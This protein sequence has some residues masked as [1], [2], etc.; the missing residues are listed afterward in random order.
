M[1]Q[2]MQLTLNQTDTQCE[3]INDCIVI[4]RILN[5][6][7][8]HQSLQL[9]DDSKLV[10][11]LME[12]VSIQYQHLIDDFNHIIIDHHDDMESIYELIHNKHKL[13]LP[14]C[15]IISC[16][17]YKRSNRNRELDH[18]MKEP[19]I[20]N[21]Q[22]MFWQDLFDQIHCFMLH[23][24]DGGLRIK[25]NKIYNN[26][27]CRRFDDTDSS[28]SKYDSCFDRNF[29][30]IC[31]TASDQNKSLQK[32]GFRG[33]RTKTN[34]FN[35]NIGFI[36]SDKNI[37]D[38]RNEPETTFMDDLYMFLKQYNVNTAT[39]LRLNEYLIEHQYDTDSVLSD[40][41]VDDNFASN[42]AQFLQNTQY[43]NCVVEYQ[44]FVERKKYEEKQREEKLSETSQQ[45]WCIAQQ[46]M[47]PYYDELRE[48]AARTSNA[49]SIGFTFFY[50]DYYR[51]GDVTQRWMGNQNDLL[52]Y[53]SS[54]LFIRKKYKSLKDEVLDNEI[55][56]ISVDIYNKVLTKAYQYIHCKTVKYIVASDE[57]NELH[58]GITEGT[59]ISIEHLLSI[60]F[61]TNLSKLSTAFSS[62]FR[63]LQKN[64]SLESIKTRNREYWHWSKLIR[65][66]VQ[67][68]GNK[69][70]HERGQ[71]FYTGISYMIL[72]AFVIRLCCP[73]STTKQEEV[74]YN[75]ANET[76]IVIRINNGSNY[77]SQ[78]LR[79]FDCSWLSC[80]HD[81]D[82]RLFC[83]GDNPLRV[84]SVTLV[85]S[86]YNLYWFL[87]PLFYLDCMVSGVMLSPNSDAA[88]CIRKRDY[89]IL[90]SLINHK[91][92]NEKNEI[93]PY[94][95]DTFAA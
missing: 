47:K 76:G 46:T 94:I 79:Y 17:F 65:E 90:M 24:F 32:L 7:Q 59:L 55:Y 70:G 51:S 25:K 48:K 40:I 11:V 21:L 62:T 57:E 31:K 13:L 93:L 23:L 29:D 77:Y 87:K 33:G 30:T 10:N 15:S 8:F 43:F 66:A 88:N 83:G 58:Y 81:E 56:N 42:I 89:N 5:A 41:V 71:P 3:S 39:I 18:E 75:F 61:Y 38:T 1:E 80:Y 20:D 36:E 9:L 84:E 16:T 49:F 26:I 85:T 44:F 4:K 35:I 67:Y 86:R 52:G 68:Y 60:L 69:L 37:Q 78:F 91:L 27:D 6:L 50:W 73:T 72:P 45:V 74:A 22:F 12:F 63:A 28:D 82:E 92:E 95:N 19:N 64:E 2:S 54:Q 14:S 53:S 34:K